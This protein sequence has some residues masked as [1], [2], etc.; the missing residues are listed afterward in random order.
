[1]KCNYCGTLK[2]I[3]ARWCSQCGGPYDTPKEGY[4]AA[5]SRTAQHI[6]Q[7]TRPHWLMGSPKFGNYEAP[8]VFKYNEAG[9]IVEKIIMAPSN[10][11]NWRV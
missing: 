8:F 11:V 6:E 2:D 5:R 10:L 4:A 3:N 7:T 1:M 9:E